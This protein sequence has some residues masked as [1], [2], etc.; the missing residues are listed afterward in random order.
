MN[1]FK[2]RAIN[3]AKDR[4]YGVAVRILGL[5]FAVIFNGFLDMWYLF[6]VKA[7]GQGIS[8]LYLQVLGLVIVIGAKAD[9]LYE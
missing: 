9:I 2:F 1:L 4:T 5:D 7:F 8:G 3:D 6:Y